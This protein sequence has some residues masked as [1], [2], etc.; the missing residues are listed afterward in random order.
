MAY[1][2]TTL[3]GR[4]TRLWARYDSCVKYWCRYWFNGSYFEVFNI[5]ANHPWSQIV[6]KFRNS[7]ISVQH[8]NHFALRQ[9]YLRTHSSWLGHKHLATWIK[10]LAYE[11]ELIMRYS[12]FNEYISS[13]CK[14]FE[15]SSL[16]Q[17]TDD[18]I[19]TQFIINRNKITVRI[20]MKRMTPIFDFKLSKD[21]RHYRPD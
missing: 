21:T 19:Q 13:T 20:S 6:T 14:P 15:T 9:F 12:T 5:L 2:L 16:E 8:V 18:A 4:L 3:A 1:N 17:E 11:S 10:R 7:A